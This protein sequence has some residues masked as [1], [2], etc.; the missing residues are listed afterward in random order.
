V[1][2][3]STLPLTEYY[4]TRGLLANVDGMGDIRTVTS[5]ILDVLDQ[6]LV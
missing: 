5:R 2:M 3:Q 1:Y 4:R 6:T